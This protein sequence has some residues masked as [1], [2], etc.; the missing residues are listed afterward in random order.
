M[1]NQ[2]MLVFMIHVILSHIYTSNGEHNP[3]TTFELVERGC[4]GSWRCG[5]GRR[6]AGEGTQDPAVMGNT[7]GPMGPRP[8]P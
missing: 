4:A 2:V 5:E 7:P 8:G 3:S 6:G 1:G